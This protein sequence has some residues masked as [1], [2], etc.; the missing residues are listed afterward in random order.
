MS[1]RPS[2]STGR[3]SRAVAIADRPR[4]AGL[5]PLDDRLVRLGDRRPVHAPDALER[6]H[7]VGVAGRRRPPVDVDD[8][9]VLIADR[10]AERQQARC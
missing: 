3:T 2:A 1:V 9:R 6:A 4:R 10:V 5:H 7:G 8:G